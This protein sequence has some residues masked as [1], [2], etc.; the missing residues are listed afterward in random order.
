MVERR[1]NNTEK[2]SH[3]VPY[4]G[5]AAES[6][7]LAPALGFLSF[8]HSENRTQNSNLCLHLL[9]LIK[10][11]IYIYPQVRSD[12]VLSNCALKKFYTLSTLE[13]FFEF[14]GRW[15]LMFIL[16]C[17]GRANKRRSKNSVFCFPSPLIIIQTRGLE[18][19]VW[20]QWTQPNGPRAWRQRLRAIQSSEKSF[21][22]FHFGCS[23]FTFYSRSTHSFDLHHAPT[24]AAQQMKTFWGE[25]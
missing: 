4:L 10:L 18:S 16:W 9:L 25:K 3:F 11:Y 14:R 15:I 6:K 8:F 13:S 22:R 23:F 19:F 20:Q 24:T 5:C 12:A 2:L 21:P 1:R 7:H 17:V